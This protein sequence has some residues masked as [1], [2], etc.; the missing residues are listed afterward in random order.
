MKRGKIETKFPAWDADWCRLTKEKWQMQIPNV[1]S[2]E[3]EKQKDFL[4]TW[5]RYEDSV[6][7]WNPSSR[8]SWL[9]QAIMIKMAKTKMYEQWSLEMLRSTRRRDEMERLCRRGTAGDMHTA[10]ILVNKMELVYTIYYLQYRGS[11]MTIR[12]RLL[13]YYVVVFEGEWR[14]VIRNRLSL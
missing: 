9:E 1:Q 8:E 5:G 11:W 2:D 6:R 13:L 3:T 14:T 12:F 10:N 4:E 7:P